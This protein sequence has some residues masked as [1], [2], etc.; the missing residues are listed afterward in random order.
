MATLR[1]CVCN[2]K[3]KA[4][5]SE[6]Y[7]TRNHFMREISRL[8]EVSAQFIFAKQIRTSGFIFVSKRRNT[9]DFA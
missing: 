7:K 9:V 5:L 8:Q 4:A 1:R 3:E 2:S 6:V